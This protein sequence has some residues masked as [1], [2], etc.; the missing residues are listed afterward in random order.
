MH[1]YDDSGGYL[2]TNEKCNTITNQYFSEK[3]FNLKLQD[4]RQEM[5]RMQDFA[6]FTLELLETMSCRGPIVSLDGSIVRQFDSPTV[7]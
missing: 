4:K 2:L 7:R 5:P 1:V 3:R 6:P